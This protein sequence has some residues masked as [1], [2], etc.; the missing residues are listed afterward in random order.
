MLNNVIIL[1]ALSIYGHHTSNCFKKF[2]VILLKGYMG[3]H[4][5]FCNVASKRLYPNTSTIRADY[6]IIQKSVSLSIRQ[7]ASSV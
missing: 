5:I 1:P 2:E 4:K 3:Y 7:I 6:K